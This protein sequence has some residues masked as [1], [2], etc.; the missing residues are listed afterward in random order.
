MAD[1]TERQL[2]MLKVLALNN[3]LPLNIG[4]S[5]LCDKDFSDLMMREFVDVSRDAANIVWA[6]ISID[7]ARAIPSHQT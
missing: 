3:G 7:G 6:R 1:L 2:V 4:L 5:E